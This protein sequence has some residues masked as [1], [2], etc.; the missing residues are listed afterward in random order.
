[1][2]LWN[3]KFLPAARLMTGRAKRLGPFFGI[4]SESI[5]IVKPLHSNSLQSHMYLNEFNPRRG[6]LIDP[7][8]TLSPQIEGEM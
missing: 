6:L 3:L 8:G 7:Y 2:T 1:M 5:L 4:L